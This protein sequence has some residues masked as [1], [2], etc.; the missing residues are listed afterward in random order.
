MINITQARL[1]Y[2]NG[3]ISEEISHL[4]GLEE[5]VKLQMPTFQMLTHV[6]HLLVQGLQLL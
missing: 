3:H 2:R 5:G 6:D 4:D 1:I